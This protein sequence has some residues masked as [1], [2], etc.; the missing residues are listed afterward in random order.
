[1]GVNCLIGDGAIIREYAE[2]ADFTIIG[3]YTVIGA[4]TTIGSHS[5]VMEFSAITRNC[6]IGDRVFIAPGVLCADD[7]SFARVR[8]P[9][10]RPQII[11]D[12]ARIGI[13]ARLLPGVVIG[14]SAIVAASSVVKHDVPARTMVAGVPAKYVRHVTK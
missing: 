4:S 8:P 7:N 9:Q 1:V 5:R 14:E 13:G 12:D 2:I 10:L 11:H 6:R 3:M